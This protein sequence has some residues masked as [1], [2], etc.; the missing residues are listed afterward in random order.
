M[1]RSDSS[2]ASSRLGYVFALTPGAHAPGYGQTPLRGEDLVY[3]FPFMDTL[4][5]DP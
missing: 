1:L 5:I 4:H 2:F 3:H